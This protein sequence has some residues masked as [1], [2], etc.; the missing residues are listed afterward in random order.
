MSPSTLD[1]PLSGIPPHH[2]LQA[3]CFPPPELLHASIICHFWFLLVVLIL[4]H[5]FNDMVQCHEASLKWVCI[6][7]CPSARLHFF[8]QMAGVISTRIKNR[9]FVS[10]SVRTS[11]HIRIYLN[12]RPGAR[13]KP[14]SQQTAET[15]HP[16][17]QV[18]LWPPS[19]VW[20]QYCTHAIC[21]ALRLYKIVP[22]F[23]HEPLGP[24]TVPRTR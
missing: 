18:L 2:L 24:Y 8:L 4:G 6:L 7:E 15:W 16:C 12:L 5:L 9:A 23:T 20:V 10:D 1:T 13:M 22:S 11:S 14:G 3:Q 19:S 21:A 17:L